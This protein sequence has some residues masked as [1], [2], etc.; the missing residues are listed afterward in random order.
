M[1]NVSFLKEKYIGF[2]ID[3]NPSKGKVLPNSNSIL[4]L[5]SN[6]KINT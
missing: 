2:F 6:P 3:S 1:N 5:G 4:F